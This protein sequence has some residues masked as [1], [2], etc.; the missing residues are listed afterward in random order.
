M[1]RIT[2]IP[3]LGHAIEVVALALFMW[4]WM[5]AVRGDRARHQSALRR[6]LAV[7]LA[8]GWLLEAL[9]MWFFGTY[10]YGRLVWWWLGDVPIYIPL[11]WAVIVHSSMALSDRA[12]VVGWARPVLDGLLAVLIDL[13]V[14]AIAIRLGLWQWR[15]ELHEGWFGVPA[16][17]LCAW[18]WV[19]FW[20][21]LGTRLVRRAVA[22]GATPWLSA[23]VPPVAY[24]GLFVSLTTLGAVGS[25]LGLET[26]D[27]RLGTFA[28]HVV[29]FMAV[30]A[31]ALRQGRRPGSPVPPS[32]VWTRWL[33]HGAFLI[34]LL[35]TGMH[36][37]VPGLAAVTVAG[38][39]LEWAVQ[40]WTERLA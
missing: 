35:A 7:A 20:Y 5:Q 25:W 15:I 31:A 32:L 18:M 12:G 22:R 19:A 40:R 37:R 21:S 13:G 8:Y 23:A 9:D 28:V 4:V 16:G 2:V 34:L 38:L 6:E 29:G 3:W 30:L 17:N 14:D 26:A 36:R 11:L 24:A 27:Q 1:D 39:V 10:H 33:I